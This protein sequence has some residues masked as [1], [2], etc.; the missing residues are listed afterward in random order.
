[1]PYTDRQSRRAIQ[2]LFKKADGNFDDFCELL[3]NALVEWN[4]EAD[5][6]IT[7]AD[8]CYVVYKII[9]RC[10]GNGRWGHRSDA[11]KILDS[12]YEEFYENFLRKYERETKQRNGD[13]T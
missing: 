7:N 6:M 8:I 1:M 9:V 3:K 2:E 11:L 5:L 12:A 4:T 10:Y 13:V